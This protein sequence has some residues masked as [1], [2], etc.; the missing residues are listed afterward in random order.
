MQI[1]ATLPISEASSTGLIKSAAAWDSDNIPLLLLPAALLHGGSQSADRA[2]LKSISTLLFNLQ[3]VNTQATQQSLK[4]M[5][6]KALAMKKMK[7]S[8]MSAQTKDTV[9]T[10]RVLLLP[11]GKYQRQLIIANNLPFYT[12]MLDLTERLGLPHIANQVL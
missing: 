9:R 7:E 4:K 12:Y 6:A 3:R 1:L 8:A 10:T 11:L 5:H 2:N